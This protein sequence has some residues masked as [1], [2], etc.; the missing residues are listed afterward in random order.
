MSS[1]DLIM[2]WGQV[3]GIGAEVDRPFDDVTASFLIVE[4]VVER[5]L[6]DYHYVVGIEVVVELLR[7]DKDGIQ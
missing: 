4:D 6:R 2:W 7:C 3:D 5:V 1:Y